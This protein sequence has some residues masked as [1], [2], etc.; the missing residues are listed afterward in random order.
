MFGTVSVGVHS[1]VTGFVCFQFYSTKQNLSFQLSG[2]AFG[3][4][5][6]GLGIVGQVFGTLLRSATG[7]SGCVWEDFRTMLRDNE[8]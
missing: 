6:V 2:D 5:C 7:N 4:F 3:R 8:L 1:V